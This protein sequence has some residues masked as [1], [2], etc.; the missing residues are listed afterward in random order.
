MTNLNDDSGQHSATS[1]IEDD[2]PAADNVPND[3]DQAKSPKK[4]D[5]GRNYGKGFIYLHLG[6]ANDAL[7]KIDTHAKHM[8]KQGFALALGHKKPNGRFVHK[9]DALEEYGLI[10][11]HKDSDDVTLTNLAV[12]M[13][14]G[15]NEKARAKSRETAFLKCE[16]F[17][18]TFTECPKNQ[19]HPLKYVRDF[20]AAKLGIRNEVDRYLRL[21]LESAKFAGLLEGEPDPKVSSI[22]LKP[23]G[24]TTTPEGAK[25]AGLQPAAALAYK[26]LVG[27]AAQQVLDSMGLAAYDGRA[28]VEER[29][30]GKVSLKF[31]DGKCVLDVTR[32]FR[33]TI[34]NTDAVTELQDIIKM[35]KESGHDI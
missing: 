30:S 20:V 35:L 19:D 25:G 7:Q 8:S 21:F 31:E 11:P 32:P 9:L 18:H 10:E 1:P 3:D 13:L 29:A 4:P 33:V 26:S 6:D 2:A 15:G 16:S 34:G 28:Q 27:D 12:D 17:R 24:T 14:Y 23:I 5:K 22:K